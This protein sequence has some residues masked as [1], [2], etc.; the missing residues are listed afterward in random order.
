MTDNA[1]WRSLQFQ[2][3]QLMHSL[4]DAWCATLTE[5]APKV[6]VRTK[7]VKFDGERSMLQIRIETR[8]Q[9]PRIAGAERALTR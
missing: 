8:R 9:N 6:H 1:I 5:H 2:S 4:T 7:A 3:L